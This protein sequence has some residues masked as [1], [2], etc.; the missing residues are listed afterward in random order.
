MNKKEKKRNKKFLQYF[1]QRQIEGLFCGS[2]RKT[3]EVKKARKHGN[4]PEPDAFFFFFL[5]LASLVMQI[6]VLPSLG[7]P[8]T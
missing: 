1:R 8:V 5:V 3:I 2:L 4:Y 6:I 7:P